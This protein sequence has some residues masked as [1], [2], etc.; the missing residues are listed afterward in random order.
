MIKRIKNNP[1]ARNSLVLFA[2]TMSANFLSYLFH[3]MAGRLVSIRVYGEAESLISLVSIISVPAA[4]LGMIATKYSAKDKAEN[5]VNGSFRLFKYLNKRVLQVGLP[6]FFLSIILTPFVSTFFNISGFIPFVSVWLLMFVSFFFAINNGILTGWQKFKETS[7][8][9]VW[10][11]AFKLAVMV[12]LIKMGMA[13]NGI[14]GSFVLGMVFSYIVS[15]F[16]LRFVFKKKNLTDTEEKAVSFSTIKSYVGPVLVGNL[17]ISVLCNADMIMA[18]HSLGDIAS[19]QY[20]ALTVVSKIIF[21][22]TGVVATVLF[23][24]S[25]ESSHKKI[26]STRILRQAFKI[27]AGLSVV[28]IFAY[29][30]FPEVVLWFIF[31]GKYEAVAVYLG[32]LSV[33]VAFFSLTNLT[34]QFLLANHKTDV[35]WALLGS[36]VLFPFFLLFWGKTIFAIIGITIANQALALLLSLYYLNKHKL[37]KNV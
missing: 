25:A 29:F 36:A 16:F 35:V 14:I 33:A 13:L 9:A 15:M 11:A 22:A 18:K 28:A 10:G 21:F 26:D 27:V 8:A 3:L 7:W 34:F 20:G 19:G 30:L 1:F 12:V 6:L 24:M 31:G 17:A 23:S 37:W 2:G 4:A 5:N 32:W